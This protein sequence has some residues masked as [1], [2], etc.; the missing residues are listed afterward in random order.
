MLYTQDARPFIKYNKEYKITDKRNKEIVKWF[1]SKRR[2]KEEDIVRG[3]CNCAL[4][5]L[6][7]SR[8]KVEKKYYKVNVM[9][10]CAS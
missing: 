4:E 3:R 2:V 10:T 6:I 8:L 5:F 9:S 1:W 7:K